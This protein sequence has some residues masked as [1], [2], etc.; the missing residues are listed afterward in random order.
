MT[1]VGR[2][3]GAVALGAVFGAATSLSNGL[4]NRLG[5][6]DGVRVQSGWAWWARVLSLTL[7]SGW[8]WAALAVAAGWLAGSRVRGSAA[9]V[10]ALVAATTAYYR[11]DAVLLAEPLSMQSATVRHWLA[12]SVLCGSVLG[13]LGASIGRPGLAGL[14]AGLTVPVGA[15]L[16]MIV[17]PPGSDPI[18]LTGADGWARLIVWAG[19]A[20][21]A[22][23]VVGRYRAAAARKAEV[24]AA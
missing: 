11:M 23:V 4:S 13:A 6:V 17:R 14:L 18:S 12:A 16:Q 1:K 19:A 22:V 24:T 7:D 21:G 2:V 10:L 9:G 8:A 20:A 15:S 5:L 3:A